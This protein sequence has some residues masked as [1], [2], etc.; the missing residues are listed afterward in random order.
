MILLCVVKTE[1]NMTLLVMQT[2]LPAMSHLCHVHTINTKA[3]CNLALRIALMFQCT[4][5]LSNTLSP[6]WQ[7]PEFL[8]THSMFFVSYFS[9]VFFFSCHNLLLHSSRWKKLVEQLPE[10]CVQVGYP[11][12][13]HLNKLFSVRHH[14]KVNLQ[15]PVQTSLKTTQS[16]NSHLSMSAQLVLEQFS[17]FHTSFH[18]HAPTTSRKK[19]RR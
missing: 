7:I 12:L 8:L 4:G 17:L 5:H 15:G 10:A 19:Q 3:H 9:S 13:S 11:W 2:I 16:A 18:S 14:C 1:L 6:P